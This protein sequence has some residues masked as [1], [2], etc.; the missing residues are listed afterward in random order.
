MPLRVAII[1][2]KRTREK[3]LCSVGD[4][5][6]LVAMMR[7]EGEF[8]RYKD[9]D[10]FIVGIVECGDCHGERAPLAL[11]LLKLQLSALK[12]TVDIIHIGTCISRIC[13]HKDELINY[14]KQNVGIEV[15]EGTHD[16]GAP[17]IFP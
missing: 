12:E 13:R 8:K 1:A 14:I 16:Y 9:K 3:N 17:R 10:A 7:K 5:K 11:G 6:C 2:C 4:E 15:I